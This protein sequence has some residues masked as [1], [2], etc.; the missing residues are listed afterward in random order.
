MKV[1]GNIDKEIY[2]CVIDDI[3]TSEVVI[4]DK[5]IEHIKERHPGDYECFYRFLGEMIA[6]P[7]YI[8]EANKPN[9]ALILKQIKLENK[10]FQLVLRL[11]T[12]QDPVEYK[13]SVIT[14]FKI[15][16]KK[17]EKYLRNKKILYRR[18]EL[19]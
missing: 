1:I 2:R 4:T 18:K 17:W 6:Q 11:K 9:T 5:Q 3:L 10:R 12:A 14:F 8:L 19:C 16:Q 7:D 15:E 13:N